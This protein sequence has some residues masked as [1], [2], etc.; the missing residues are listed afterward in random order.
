MIGDRVP[1]ALAGER[2]DR[3]VAI[4]ADVSRS[5]AAAAIAAGGVRVDGDVAESGKVR[6]VEGVR[7]EVDPEAFPKVVMPT[8]DADVVFTIVHVDDDR[9]LQRIPE[10]AA[11]RCVDDAV[12]GVGVAP[13]DG[14][15]APSRRAIGELPRQR[16]NGVGGAGDDEQPRTAGI[17]PVHDAWP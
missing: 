16:R 10:V 4:L 11:D 13:H 15:V 6:L 7:V 12:G 1:S 17:E 14:V 5:A 3:V 8:G 2:L 9:H